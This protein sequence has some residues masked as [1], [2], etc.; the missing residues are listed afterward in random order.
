MFDCCVAK[1][2]WEDLNSLFGWNVDY[3]F[4]TIVCFWLSPKKY[5][6]QNVVCAAILWVLWKTQNELHF[7]VKSWPGVHKL[8]VRVA[9]TMRGWKLISKTNTWKEI[10]LYIG[11]LEKREHESKCIMWKETSSLGASKD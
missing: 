10:D 8:T 1:C 6:I 2:L 3:N 9:Q 11:A 5:V 7:Q 4:E